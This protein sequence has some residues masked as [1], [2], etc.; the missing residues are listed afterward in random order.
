MTLIRIIWMLSA[1]WIGA[2][3]LYTLACLF[4]ITIIGI[5]IAIV[6]FQLGNRWL[7]LRL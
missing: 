7:T 1:G 6:L 4:A 2:I 3:I 5:P